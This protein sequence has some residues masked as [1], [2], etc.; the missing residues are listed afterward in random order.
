MLIIQLN[1]LST[2]DAPSFLLWS[3]ICIWNCL[4]LY[5]HLCSL[6]ICTSPPLFGT[7]GFS[8][9]ETAHRDNLLTKVLLL[10]LISASLLCNN[11]YHYHSLSFIVILFSFYF[12]TALICSP[13]NCCSRHKWE[14]SDNTLL[15]K[16]IKFMK[17]MQ[18]SVRRK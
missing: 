7:E 18:L 9:W 13:R 15:V 16:Q 8:C 3:I 11:Y 5:F 14:S 2:R 6:C 10:S 1:C 4:Y 12:T 17:E